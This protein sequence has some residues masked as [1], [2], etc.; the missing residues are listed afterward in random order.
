MFRWVDG[1]LMPRDTVHCVRFNNR[2]E[3]VRMMT[4]FT[5][6]GWSFAYE[7]E[8]DSHDVF[9]TAARDLEMIRKKFKP[10]E[11]MV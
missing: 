2:R 3:A 5:V 4:H 8:E 9:V 11:I 1:Q 6:R 7:K 10:T